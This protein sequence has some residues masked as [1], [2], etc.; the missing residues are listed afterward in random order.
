MSEKQKG[1]TNAKGS[2]H[3]WEPTEEQLQKMSAAALARWERE[4][5][6]GYVMPEEHRENISKA[7]AGNKNALGT[8][9]KPISEEA[10]AR[11]KAAAQERERKKR[12]SAPPKE[13]T[14]ISP[15]AKAEIAHANMSKAQLGNQNGLGTHRT[16]E[17]KD[18]IGDGIKKAWDRRKKSGPIVVSEETRQKL[19][20]AQ[21]RRRDRE[22]KDKE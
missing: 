19:K 22:K 2:T 9:H 8:K 18:N 4:K 7:M 6:N 12:E 5:E 3:E 15:E 13:N 1:N 17:Q 11:I 20:D 14:D 16:D 21:K 10:I